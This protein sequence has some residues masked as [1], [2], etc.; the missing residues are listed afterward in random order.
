[1]FFSFI[2]RLI[3]SFNRHN[4]LTYTFHTI[5]SLVCVHVLQHFIPQNAHTKRANVYTTINKQKQDDLSKQ[6]Q[7]ISRTREKYM[8][9]EKKKNN[10]NEKY[11]PDKR[12]N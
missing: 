10:N 5:C 6:K 8:K 11:L 7:P 9:K 4:T 2:C 1:M 12:I 3:P